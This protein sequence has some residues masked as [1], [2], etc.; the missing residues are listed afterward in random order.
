MSLPTMPTQPTDVS[1]TQGG[2]KG[3]R[4]GDALESNREVCVHVTPKAFPS[5]LYQE[6]N[7]KQSEEFLLNLERKFAPIFRKFKQFEQLEPERLKH[8]VMLC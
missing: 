5:V 2:W 6:Q 3:W 1:Q 7:V 8:Q 4:K